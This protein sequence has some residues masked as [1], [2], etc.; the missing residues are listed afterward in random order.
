VYSN[1]FCDTIS[2]LSK[3]IS[4]RKI[5]VGRINDYLIMKRIT[6]K[7]MRIDKN[8]KIIK[9]KIADLNVS[10]RSLSFVRL[11][12]AYS[13]HVITNAISAAINPNT[14]PIKIEITNIADN[15]I[16]LFHI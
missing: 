10:L 7:P 16:N 5:L 11:C 4:P 3:W 12:L 9:A 14:I 6:R 2:Y 8:R 13:C 15:S 1:L